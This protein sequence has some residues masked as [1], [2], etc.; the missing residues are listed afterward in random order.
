M[1]GSSCCRKHG[2]QG[3]RLLWFQPVSLVEAAP[4]QALKHSGSVAVARELSGPQHVGSSQTRIN[5][6]LLHWQAEFLLTEPLGKPRKFLLK[7]PCHYF[8]FVS[9]P[10]VPNLQEHHL[11]RIGTWKSPQGKAHPEANFPSLLISFQHPVFPN[12]AGS[13][14]EKLGSPKHMEMY[15]RVHSGSLSTGGRGRGGS[16]VWEPEPVKVVAALK[17]CEA[18]RSQ[19]HQ[20]F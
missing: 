2:L 17:G 13:S 5:P 11:L 9:F 6:R 3:V 15:K 4:S 7:A 16:Q 20:N 12:P 8:L 19:T 14:L 10:S 1:H 18:E